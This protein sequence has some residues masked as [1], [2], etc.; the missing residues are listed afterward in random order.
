MHR[1]TGFVIVAIAGFLAAGD[2]RADVTSN[3]SAGVVGPDDGGLVTETVEQST[4]AIGSTLSG[5]TLNRSI[6]AGC[7]DVIG[8]VTLAAPAPAGGLSVAL[9]DTLASATAPLSVTVPGGTLSR[10]FIIRTKPVAAA[11]S[12]AVTATL[13]GNTLSKDLVVRPMGVMSLSLSPTTVVGS[14]P[15]SGIAKLEC[16]AGPDPVTVQLSSSRP[17]IAHPVATS[18]VVPVGLQAQSFDIVTSPALSKMSVAIAAATK[19]TMKS[20]A[21]V[22]TPAS[23]VIPTSLNFGEQRVQLSS[24]A[25]NTTLRNIGAVPFSVDSITLVGTTESII[26]YQH[27]DNCPSILPAGASCT[28]SVKFSPWIY[29]GSLPA[30]LSIATGARSV[31]LLVALSGTAFGVPL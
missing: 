29:V 3:V 15:S 4:A 17:A 27:T 11:Q 20:K 7:K 30:K 26:S 19:A 14:K 31:P 9:K 18:L 2:A 23:I 10:N 5:L 24:A 25:L 13:E 12:G 28:I 21:L 16:E 8:T 1:S 6:V 22:V